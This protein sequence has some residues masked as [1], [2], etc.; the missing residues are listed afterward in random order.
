AFHPVNPHA[1]R[2]PPVGEV[3]EAVDVLDLR[4]E[5]ALLVVLPE[6]GGR[7]LEILR[8][9]VR[10]RLGNLGELVRQPRG[11]PGSL[12]RLVEDISRGLLIWRQVLKDGVH[13][14]A[15]RLERGL[16]GVELRLALERGELLLKR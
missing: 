2:V 7:R 12:E 8:E 1:I 11:H 6:L 15:E 4:E 13:H 16:K 14:T 5:L 10:S 3:L 9:L